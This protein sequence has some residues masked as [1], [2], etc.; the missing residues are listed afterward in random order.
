MEIK[1][2]I[3]TS[4]DDTYLPFLPLT[5]YSWN[6]LGVK[7]IVT[8]D[9]ETANSTNFKIATSATG[10]NFETLTF[11]CQDFETPTYCQTSR[12]FGGI[13]QS[14]DTVLITGDVD[15]CVFSKDIL[16]D[17]GNDITV[18]GLDLIPENQIN[19][20]TQVP[21]CYVLMKVSTWKKVMSFKETDDLT[22][23]LS[24]ALEIIKPI[25]RVDNWFFDQ[26]YLSKAIRESSIPIVS[27]DRRSS[28]T[29]HIATRRAD[30]E[31]WSPG[32]KFNNLIDAHLPRPL[33]EP[34]NF[35]KILD[36]FRDQYP[37]DDLTWLENYYA[38][39]PFKKI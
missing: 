36:L 25:N 23:V 6:K 38:N 30:R 21:I 24:S 8:T 20:I 31:N 16:V 28:D 12:L 2:V 1:A 26:L 29:S 18:F 3:S 15:M 5:I 34:D 11:T 19:S 32:Q 10:L 14:D 33:S 39:F 4:G 27:I 7:V 9:I 17:P 35:D 37:N 13:N 22:E